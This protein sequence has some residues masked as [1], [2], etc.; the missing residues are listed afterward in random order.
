MAIIFILGGF[1]GGTLIGE[2]GVYIG[3]LGAIGYAIY[4]VIDE[5]KD[6]K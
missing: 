4:K 6:K 1:I 5:N 2:T 3:G